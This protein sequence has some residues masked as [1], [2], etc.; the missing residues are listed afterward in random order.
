MCLFLM[1]YQLSLMTITTRHWRL[2]IV[3]HQSNLKTFQ[4]RRVSAHFVAK[5]TLPSEIETEVL[6]KG[7]QSSKFK[8]SKF[9]SVA[10]AKRLFRYTFTS[11]HLKKKNGKSCILC[12]CNA[13]FI[14]Q[15]RPWFIQL[16]CTTDYA[17]IGRELSARIWDVCNRRTNHSHCIRVVSVSSF[18]HSLKSSG[19][20]SMD[21][22]GHTVSSD[23]AAVQQYDKR[24]RIFF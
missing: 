2:A 5:S 11:K 15:S 17:V 20:L 1:N 4:S 16:V 6:K 8:A 9:V 24:W 14:L 3:I 12:M 23:W 19:L 21:T 22:D 18:T 10:S 13:Q 7:F